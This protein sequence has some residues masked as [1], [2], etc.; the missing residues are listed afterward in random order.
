MCSAGSTATSVTLTRTAGQ[1]LILG[2]SGQVNGVHGIAAAVCAVL[3]AAALFAEFNLT[4]LLLELA[5]TTPGSK[6]ASLEE[7][8]SHEEKKE[9]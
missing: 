7:H 9:N 8:K 3:V 6:A 2:L 1:P 5:R 4:A